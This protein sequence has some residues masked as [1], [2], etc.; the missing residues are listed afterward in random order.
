MFCG[1]SSFPRRWRVK[2]R[3]FADWY[4]RIENGHKSTLCGGYTI[5]PC[6]R[7]G[8]TRDFVLNA[9]PHKARVR[10][11]RRGCE[12]PS[13]YYRAMDRYT[14]ADSIRRR[15]GFALPAAAQRLKCCA[16]SLMTFAFFTSH[17]FPCRAQTSPRGGNAA[18]RAAYRPTPALLRRARPRISGRNKI[19]EKHRRVFAA[20]SRFRNRF[21]GGAKPAA[22]FGCGKSRSGAQHFPAST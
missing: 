22:G 10:F 11:P 13:A 8:K 15:L 12:R 19:P 9:E 17:V 20:D 2:L 4:G 14:D 6:L 3:G 18:H 5:L 7:H 21:P 16:Y 1:Y